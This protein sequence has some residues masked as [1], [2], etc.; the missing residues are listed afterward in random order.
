M[1]QIPL[2]GN[3]AIRALLVHRPTFDRPEAELW[4]QVGG[5]RL[6]DG[7]ITVPD[8][9]YAPEVLA[10]VRDL[11]DL[12]FVVPFDWPNWEE[13]SR[14][15][16]APEGIA[17]ASLEDCVKLLT[18]IVRHD[19]FVWGEAFGLDRGIFRLILQRLQILIED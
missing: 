14:L 11:Y 13:G 2:P 1:S 6:P 9:S 10:F 17:R 4:T 3:E 15:F 7:S 18:A 16:N 19:R 5:D 8:A 12:G